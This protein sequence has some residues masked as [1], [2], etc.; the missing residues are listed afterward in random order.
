MAPFLLLCKAFL[1]EDAI[2]LFMNTVT[3]IRKIKNLIARVLDKD[4]GKMSENPRRDWALVVLA[5]LATALL[6]VAIGFYLFIRVKS[7]EIFVSPA[8]GESRP[9]ID[10]AALDAVIE[11]NTKKKDFVKDLLQN[12]PLFVDPSR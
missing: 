5:F 2:N 8:Q 4:S 3:P 9:V 10:R 7:G 6:F 12:P 1:R 11:L